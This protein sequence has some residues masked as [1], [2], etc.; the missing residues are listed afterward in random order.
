MKTVESPPTKEELV[1]A[2]DDLFY[3]AHQSALYVYWKLVE[4]PIA[5]SLRR[6]GIPDA[7]VYFSNGI[8]ESSLL[9]IRKTTE[10]FK[11]QGDRDPHDTLYAYRYL[12]GW[13]GIWL[14]AEDGLY[15]ELHK[16]VGHIT[17]RESRYGKQAWPILELTVRAVDQWI[18]FFCAVAH[19]GI[20]DGNPPKEKL[21]KFV[22]SLR[23]V[24]RG[25]HLLRSNDK[26]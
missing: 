16:R 26:A 17:V 2:I 11:P 23:E 19:S 4:S 20:F 24:S 12:D 18:A 10:F 9:L 22:E 15:G 25:C 5:S 21:D 8:L 13:S 14:V 6:S 1:R 7:Q 3:A